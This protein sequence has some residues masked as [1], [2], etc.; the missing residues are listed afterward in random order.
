M[1]VFPDVIN[2]RTFSVTA[3]CL[4]ASATI[5]MMVKSRAVNLFKKLNLMEAN[6][7]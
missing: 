3:I 6:S 2:L 5:I 1:K 7:S 4:K